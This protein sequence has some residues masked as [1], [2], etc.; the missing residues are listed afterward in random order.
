VKGLA[1]VPQGL[2]YLEILFAD[3]VVLKVARGVKAKVP[4]P[5]AFLLHKLIVATLSERRAKR[6][7]D[8]R[9]AVYVGK[10]VLSE[11][12]ELARLL[13]L[14]RELPHKWK[15]R[16]GKALQEARQAVP[17]EQGVVA[18]LRQILE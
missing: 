12:S 15:V 3:P 1:V 8:L 6:E 16:A 7:K 14:W 11:R 13:R 2:R 4:A 18:R 9:Q 10:F 5:A 17:L